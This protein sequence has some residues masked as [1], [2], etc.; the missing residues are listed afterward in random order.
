MSAAQGIRPAI[1]VMGVSGSGKTT[2]GRALALAHGLDF[3]DGDDL[4]PAANVAKMH[5][6]T[7][8]DDIDRAPWLDAVGAT[9][10]DRVAHPAGI[11]VACSALKRTYRDRL[12]VASGGCRFLYLALPRE[13]AVLRVGHRPGHFMPAS[14][15][16]NQFATLEVPGPDEQDVTTADAG[17]PLAAI[18]SSFT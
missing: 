3:V 7:P 9:L 17:L 2:I 8:L 5:A 11:V 13:T 16:A 12:R 14:L 4:H 10:A 18:I 15:V 1:V 6:G